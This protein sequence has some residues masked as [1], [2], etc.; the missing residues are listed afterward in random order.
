MYHLSNRYYS[1]DSHGMTHLYP[2][3]TAMGLLCPCT[4][5]VSITR[6]HL[7]WA[8]HLVCRPAT[9]RGII[10][11]KR[12]WQLHVYITAHEIYSPPPP[13]P[14]PQ[15]IKVGEPEIIVQDTN[16][17]FNRGLTLFFWGCGTFI[18]KCMPMH[19]LP[20]HAVKKRTVY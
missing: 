19:S 2:L 6:I 10:K 3:I 1:H 9:N 7:W 17:L 16:G 5:N 18:L 14:P 12:P 15:T 4:G 20:S 11:V 8:Y 13:P